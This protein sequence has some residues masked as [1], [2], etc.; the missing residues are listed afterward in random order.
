MFHM[1]IVTLE[2][3]Y[4][5]IDAKSLVVPGSDG[6]LGILAHHAPLISALKP[7]RIEYRDDADKVNILAVSGGFI[8]V[9]DNRVTLLADTVE[10]GDEID[11]QRAQDAHD[12]ARKRLSAA[13][14]KGAEIS[15]ER[16]AAALARALN[17]IKIYRETH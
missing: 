14:Q 9:S 10:S 3:V 16:A 13:V 5:E 1:S 2:R 6:Y 11:I 8:E 12:R 7:G 17:R 4:C 15:I